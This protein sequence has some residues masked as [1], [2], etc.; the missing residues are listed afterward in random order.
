METNSSNA[1]EK[2]IRYA[3]WYHLYNFKD[4]KHT[5][6]GVFRLVKL[7]AQASSMSIFHVFKIVQMVPNRVTHHTDNFITSTGFGSKRAEVMVKVNE[8]YKSI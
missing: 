6:G 1:F 8:V 3:I 2:V 7:Q 5:H 4:V